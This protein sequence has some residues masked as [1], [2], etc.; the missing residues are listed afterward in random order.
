MSAKNAIAGNG[1]KVVFPE[2]GDERILKAAALLRDEDLAVPILL[3]SSGTN[4]EDVARGCGISTDGMEISH[5][6]ARPN[7]ELLS[8]T[9]VQLKPELGQDDLAAFLE[10][11]L[12]V[13]G[14]MVAVGDADAMI[15]GAVSSTANV[16]SAGLRTVGMG[17]DHKRLSSYFLMCPSDCASPSQSS[18]HLIFAD[19]A[20]NID[21]DAEQLCEIT[22]AS[23]ASGARLLNEDRNLEEL[24]R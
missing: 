7:K 21:P 2:G 8:G 18:K 5:V 23:A 11:P 9:M 17:A 6:S 13:A 20:V 15:A 4:P 10:E 19:C 16:I 22:I 24:H 3:W 12:Y 1:L 14:C